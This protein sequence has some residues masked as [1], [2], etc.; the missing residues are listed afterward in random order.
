MT[1]E[2]QDYSSIIAE[3][4]KITDSFWRNRAEMILGVSTPYVLDNN[5]MTT[6]DE[7]RYIF[8]SIIYDIFPVECLFAYVYLYRFK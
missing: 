3:I 6:L 8:S 5:A 1:D 2:M 4:F 7:E